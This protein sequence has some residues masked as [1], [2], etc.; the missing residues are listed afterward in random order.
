MY[1]RP[2]VQI[3]VNHYCPTDNFV[4]KDVFATNLMGARVGAS[5]L[6]DTDGDGLSDQ[7]E[8]NPANIAKYGINVNLKYSLQALQQNQYYSDLVLVT[9]GLDAKARMNL[10]DCAT[11]STSSVSPGTDSDN[12][13]LTDCEELLLGTDPYNADTDGD[14]I[15]DG[16]EVRMGLNPLDGT[17]GNLDPDQ[18]G[19]SSYNEIKQNLPWNI[20]N[21]EFISPQAYRYTTNSYLDSNSALCHD[22]LIQNVPVMETA[23]GNEV[24]VYVT[25]KGPNPTNPTGGEI[26]RLKVF[27][28][29]FASSV[30]DNVILSV[31]SSNINKNS[32][33][34]VQTNCYADTGVQ[35]TCP[36]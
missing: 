2:H 28:F 24:V 32:A 1:I 5:I 7:F 10:R 20:S 19:I 25:E 33:S 4:W 6:P 27:N 16:L 3:K 29:W 36:P 15:P 11:I 26:T 9:M 17:D 30:L 21:T 13:G 23:S 31:T 34:L 8:Q 35:I 14:G 12:D 22:F 18:D